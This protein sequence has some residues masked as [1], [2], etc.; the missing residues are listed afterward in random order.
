MLLKIDAVKNLYVASLKLITS[1][2][3]SLLPFS[4]LPVSFQ[5][6]SALT[7]AQTLITRT[8]SLQI[9]KVSHF[10]H[11]YLPSLLPFSL[12]YQFLLPKGIFLAL[13]SLTARPHN[14]TGG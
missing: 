2:T 11:Q 4:P 14:L 13:L 3:L 5:A 8:L 1:P 9:L 6:F 10:K 7:S 12:K